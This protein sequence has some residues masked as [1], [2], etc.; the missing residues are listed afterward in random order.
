MSGANRS[1]GKRRDDMV[2]LGNESE[3][4]YRIYRSPDFDFYAFLIHR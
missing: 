3:T 1:V 4:K 2:A